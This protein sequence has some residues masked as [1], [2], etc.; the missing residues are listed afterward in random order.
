VAIAA[1]AKL[2]K[3]DSQHAISGIA[4]GLAEFL[5]FASSTPRTF[6]F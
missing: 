4:L 2:P 6:G 5:Q 1:F 3:S